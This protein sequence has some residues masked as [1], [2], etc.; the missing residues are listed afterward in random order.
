MEEKEIPPQWLEA[1]LSLLHQKCNTTSAM[2]YRP[3]TVSNCTYIVLARLI[4]DA[5]QPINTTLSD[6]QV[7]SRKG[8]T[9]SEQAMNLVMELHE[10][11]EGSYICLLHIAKA[12]PS[13]PHGCLVESLRILDAPPHVVHV[14]E[15]IHTLITCWYGK[16]HFPLTGGKGCYP[17]LLMGSN[18]T[19]TM[20][21]FAYTACS[22]AMFV[23]IVLGVGNTPVFHV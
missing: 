20:Q 12:F 8:Y 11:P 13:T 16:L 15:S 5:I 1:R 17:H 14:V 3:I 21:N 19:R 4:L 22:G 6:T 2:N 9:T 7:G 10:R 18:C 23:T